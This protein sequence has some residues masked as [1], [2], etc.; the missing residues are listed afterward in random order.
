MTTTFLWTAFYALLALVFV[1]MIVKA[2]TRRARRE[3]GR[4]YHES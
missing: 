1:A 3:R 4:R 2:I